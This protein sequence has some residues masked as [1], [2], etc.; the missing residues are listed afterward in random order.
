MRITFF[1]FSSAFNTIQ[2]AHL[3]ELELTGVDS[4]LPHQ[5]ATACEDLWLCVEHSCLQQGTVPAPILFTLYTADFSHQSPHRHLQKFSD[6]PA[7]VGLIRDRYDRAYREL[8]K[9]FVDWCQRSRLQLIV[10]KT[11]AGGE[12]LQ[13]QTTLH[14]S[15]NLEIGNWDGDIYKYIG[16]HL[17]NKLDLSDHTAVTCKKGQSSIHLLRK[18]R[19]FGVMGTP[20]TEMHLGSR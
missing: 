16:V 10:G 18:L 12:F 7:I 9:D 14:T 19:S 5:L 6:N 8:I 17:N 20:A 1:D 2:S 13:A 4:W 11:K 15:E 3:G